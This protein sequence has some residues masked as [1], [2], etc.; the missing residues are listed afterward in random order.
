[1][2]IFPFHDNWMEAVGHML[3]ILAVLTALYVLLAVG[4]RFTDKREHND[5]ETEDNDNEQQD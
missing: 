1:M 3:V 2:M 5:S 4:R